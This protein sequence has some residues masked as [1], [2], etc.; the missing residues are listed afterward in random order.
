ML[1][2]KFEKNLWHFNI[3]FS[4]KLD[5]KILVLCGPS[6]AGKTTILHCLAGLVSPDTGDI[7]L[8]NRLL[9]SSKN[10]IN[11][12]AKDR[13][14]A[15]LFQNYALFPHMTVKQNVYYGL[16]SRKA[17]NFNFYVEPIKWLDTFGIKHLQERYPRQLSGGEKQRV[18]LARALAVQPQLLLLDE[19][20]SAL[21]KS[22]KLN[23]RQEI[24][25]LHDNWQ[26]PFILVT[27][28]EEDANF[29]GDIVLEIDQGN[30]RRMTTK[31]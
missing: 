14:I 16:K 13:N 4:L 2:A 5:N 24:K 25:K 1:E 19:P 23:L 18:A 9:Y 22:N 27:H 17:R 3:E 8:N 26:I 11:T 15:Y 10:K 29:L 21:D 12:A 7:C 30:I 31:P 20:F 28:D 6:G